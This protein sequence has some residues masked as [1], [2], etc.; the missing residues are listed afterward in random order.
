MTL[1][2]GIGQAGCNLASEMARVPGARDLLDVYLAN[3][4]MRDLIH[5]TDVPRDHWIGINETEGFVPLAG[6]AGGQE[7]EVTGGMGKDPRRCFEALTQV[8]DPIQDNLGKLKVDFQK[9]RFALL[10]FSGGGGT[11]SGA[12]PVLA[13]AI[14][15]MTDDRCRVIGGLVLPSTTRG[16][17]MESGSLREGWNA[18]F[19]LKQ[20]LEAFDGLVLIDNDRLSHLG[21]IERAFPRFNQY[22]ARCLTDMVLGNLTELALPTEGGVVLQQNDVADLTTALSLGKPGERKCGV[23]AIGRAVQMLRNPLGYLMPFL[24]IQQPDLVGLSLL[25]RERLSMDVQEGGVYEKAYLLVRAPARILD[26]AGI[27]QDIS[28]VLSLT[29]QSARRAE[30]IYGTALTNRPL[31]SVTVGL[32]FDPQELPRLQALEG[33]AMQYEWEVEA[34]VRA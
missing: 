9:E 6:L 5:I 24:P 26:R 27:G 30:V 19:S 21:D 10:L 18:W 20:S 11:G 17:A 16:E 15:R 14:K 23:A 8:M 28:E 2:F 1:V 32:T 29:S 4:T 3:S 25:A 13:R 12:A 31:A 7:R 33:N 22:I 34:P